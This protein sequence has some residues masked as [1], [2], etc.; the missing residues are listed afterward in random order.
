MGAGNC[1]FFRSEKKTHALGL[2]FVGQKTIDNGNRIKIRSRLSPGL[3]D[4]SA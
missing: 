1:L 3:W 2:R 4:F